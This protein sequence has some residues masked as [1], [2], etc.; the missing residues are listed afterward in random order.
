MNV[1]MAYSTSPSSAKKKR[2]DQKFHT[3][4]RI[5]HLLIILQNSL[6]FLRENFR[7]A[8][9]SFVSGNFLKSENTVCGSAP[10]TLDI[11]GLK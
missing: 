10:E 4:L 3:E 1:I 6:K 5:T 9:N 7:K 8:K 2:Y 11:P